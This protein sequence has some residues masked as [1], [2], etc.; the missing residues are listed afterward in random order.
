MDSQGSDM[1]VGVL[2]S[3]NYLFRVQGQKDLKTI[4]C[5]ISSDAEK[6]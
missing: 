6:I 5:F 4:F 2:F 3:T 1:F